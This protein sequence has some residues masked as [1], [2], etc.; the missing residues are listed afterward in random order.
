[1]H[2]KS[3]LF[4]TPYPQGQAPSQRFRFEQYLPILKKNNHQFKISPFLT[5]KAWDT[6][7]K[8]GK[9]ISKLYYFFQGFVTRL[10][11]IVRTPYYDFIFIHREATPVGPPFFEWII[12]KIL[13]KK[14]IYDF[15]DAIWLE[16]PDEKGS[17]K[18]MVKWKSKVSSI[19]RWSYKVSTGNEYLAKY[20]ANFCTNVIINPTTIDTEHLHNP[21]ITVNPKND[22]NLVIGWTGTHS[23]LQYLN[24]L[25]PIIAELE[26]IFDFNFIIISNK[27]PSFK[28]KSLKFIPW[29]KNTEIKDL[30][31]FDIGVMPLTND[32]WSQGKCGFKALQYMA[33]G[34]PAIASPVG[35]NSLIIDDN[36]NG[37]LCH[38][39]EEWKKNIET[40]IINKDKRKL[41]GRSAR[42]KV[43]NFYSVSSNSD[44]FLSLFSLE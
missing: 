34:I 23:T 36:E 18:S 42:K 7:Y 37:F 11:D 10:I 19:C 28:L 25:V 21:D 26:E 22:E 30:Q 1:M 8:D 4:I 9:I 40:L 6:L 33:L 27:A 3:I 20:A 2:S 41:F 13:R 39:R 17:I 12:S 29:N 38:T 24:P 44:N 15:D 31:R 35:V 5:K 14:I 16:D 32:L 43:E